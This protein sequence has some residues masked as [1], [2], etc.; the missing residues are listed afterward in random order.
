MKIMTPEVDDF[1]VYSCSSEDQWG[2]EQFIPEH[3]LAYQVSGETH[4]FHQQ[5]TFVLKK[6]QLLLAHRNQFAK[7]LKMPASDNEYKAVSVILKSEDL[8]KFAAVN[9]IICDKPYSGKYNLVLKPDPY[10]K[11]YFQ[12]L[13][14][15]LEQPDG[16]SKKMVFSK[17]TEAIELLLHI[18]PELQN[19]LFDFNEPHKINL[20][21]FM[22]KNFQYN[23]P[24]ENFAKL[25][26]RSLAGFKR[27]FSKSFQVPP[28][29]WLKEKRL[30]EAYYLIHQ[31]NKKPSDIYLDLGFENLPHFYTS[32]KQKY[33]VTPTE[34]LTINK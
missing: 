32:F 24:I 10:L 23:A 27:D 3:I 25:T 18:H 9:N 14:P 31:K 5:G 30:E 16:S 34:S 29:K 6:N 17:V 28:A 20:K 11:S 21:E 8:K 1:F 33:G 12:S 4:I 19:F 7:S 15:Y 2:Y 26:G 22:L 13:I